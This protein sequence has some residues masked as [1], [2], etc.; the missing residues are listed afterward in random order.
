[1]KLKV[2]RFASN[3]EATLGALFVDG[4]LECFTVEDEK[5]SKKVWGETRIPA[6]TYKVVFTTEGSH[7]TRYKVKF[8]EKHHGMLHIINVPNFERILIH[9][10]NSEKDTAGCLLVGVMPFLNY[11]VGQSTVA[12]EKLY[13]K[14]SKALLNGNNVE[15]EYVDND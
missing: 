13:E 5:R 10:G 12:Y 7:H 14:V 9:I 15:I 3:S 11:T 1:M 2:N 6:G 8:G 4:V